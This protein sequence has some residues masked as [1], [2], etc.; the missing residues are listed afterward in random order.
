MFNK[1]DATAA[2]Q[3][4]SSAAPGSTKSVFSSDLRITGEVTSAGTLEIQGEVDGNVTARSRLSGPEGRVRGA[5]GARGIEVKGQLDGKV[6]TQSF[7]LRAPARV[8]ADITY[9]SVVIESGA[10]IEGHF[11][12]AKG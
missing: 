9:S 5:G 2:P 6:A 3:R 12:L 7:T 4:P 1:T 8:A 11:A 10:S